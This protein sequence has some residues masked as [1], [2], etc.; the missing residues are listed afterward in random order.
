MDI[1]ADMKTVEQILKEV[2]C[3]Q[4]GVIA[5]LQVRVLELEAANRGQLSTIK[6]LNEEL[7]QQP[8]AAPPQPDLLKVPLECDC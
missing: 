8:T 2:I 5:H 1:G 7:N 4:V 3:E 6:K